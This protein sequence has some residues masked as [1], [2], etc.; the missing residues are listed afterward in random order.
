M[1]TRSSSRP[2]SRHAAIGTDA[3]A[4]LISHSV[5]SPGASP[6]RSST[7]PITFTAPRPVSFGSTAAEAQAL[8]EPSTFSPADRAKS[9]SASVSAA[10]ASLV[11]LLLPAVMENPSISGCST[12]SD[13][14]FSR[15][16]SRRGCSSTLNSTSASSRPLIFNGTIS[17]TKAPLSIAAI[18][19][20][21]ERNAHASISS[22]LIP[23]ACA[24]FHPTVIDMSRPG[25]S[26][27]STCVGG[28]HRSS[29][30]RVG[31]GNAP[32]H[33][34][35]HRQRLHAATDDDLLGS[36]ADLR[37]RV[38]DRGE[39]TRAVPVDRL[40]GNRRHA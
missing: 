31:P 37:G 17:S 22:R 13:A 24:V 23:T 27:V 6:A 33:Q 29:N 10:A 35:G 39:A 21:C 2:Y 3:N 32:V 15:L 34:R 20:W 8:T 4:S 14:S 26:G 25:A 18:A 11:P 36:G 1:L 30:S 16:V 19:R 5:T 7:L 28:I 12:F 38:G 40:T 9:S